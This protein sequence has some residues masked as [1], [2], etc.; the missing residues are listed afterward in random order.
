MSF[1]WGIL[2]ARCEPMWMKNSLNFSAIISGPSISLPFCINFLQSSMYLFLFIICLTV[3]HLLF[4]SFLFFSKSSWICSFSAI[5]SRWFSLFLIFLY[6]SHLIG[7]F[8]CE[9]YS[10]IY[11]YSLLIFASLVWAKVFYCY[12]W[13]WL[14]LLLTERGTDYCLHH[15]CICYVV[16]PLVV[17]LFSITTT[18][19]AVLSAPWWVFCSP[20]PLLYLTSKLPFYPDYGSVV[21]Q[22]NDP[23]SMIAKIHH[24]IFIKQKTNEIIL[25]SWYLRYST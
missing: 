24:I 6:F 16:C 1:I 15:Y 25:W 13:S 4:A 8:F 14:F 5:W 19:S 11:F 23:F 17:V 20:S 7:Y 10:I 21:C 9:M 22:L 3:A 18:A 12:V 2:S